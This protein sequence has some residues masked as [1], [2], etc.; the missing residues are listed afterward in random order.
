MYLSV[1]KFIAA[2]LEPRCVSLKTISQNSVC[3]STYYRKRLDTSLL[4]CFEQ[5][6]RRQHVCPW[7]GPVCHPLQVQRRHFHRLHHL[8]GQNFPFL[9]FLDDAKLYLGGM[10]QNCVIPPK[11]CVIPSKYKNFLFQMSELPF[12]WTEAHSFEKFLKISS[13]LLF[14]VVHLGTSWLFR[15][16]TEH[17]RDPMVFASPRF[18]GPCK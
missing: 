7:K 18:R 5:W 8:S 9:F 1:E 3:D 13:V 15:I 2:A 10:T 14:Y 17:E 6:R 16:S 4:R 12:S 11:Y